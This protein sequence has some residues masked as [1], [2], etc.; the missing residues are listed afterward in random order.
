MREREAKKLLR[1]LEN[2]KTD[3]DKPATEV[4]STREN[5]LDSNKELSNGSNCKKE[6][7]EELKDLKDFNKA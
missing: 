6:A 2:I 4:S 5:V 1:E 7:E 3:D